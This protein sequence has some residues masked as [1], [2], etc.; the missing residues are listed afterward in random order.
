MILYEIEGE[1]MRI[2]LIVV[3]GQKMK[4]MV[5]NLTSAVEVANNFEKQGYICEIH[6]FAE[7]KIIEREFWKKKGNENEYKN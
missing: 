3:E 2:Y 5:D 7:D 6:S 1:V 4:Y